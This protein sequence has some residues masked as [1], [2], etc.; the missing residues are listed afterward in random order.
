[1]KNKC[2]SDITIFQE[3]SRL[4]LLTPRL[5]FLKYHFQFAVCLLIL[6]VLITD[7]KFKKIFLDVLVYSLMI[8][9]VAFSPF[10]LSLFFPIFLLLFFFF[11]QKF[12]VY[13]E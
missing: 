2:A 10:F 13:F 8:S 7:K 11:A 4:R 9:T 1:M 5:E 3:F 6:F 12:L